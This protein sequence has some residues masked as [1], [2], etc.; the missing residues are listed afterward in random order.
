MLVTGL[1][2]S[3]K[4]TFARAL[5]ERDGLPHIE[6]DRMYYGP[7]FEMRPTF[8]SELS[9]VLDGP[10]WLVD[11]IGQPESR[12]LSWARADVLIWLDLP[13]GVAGVRALRRTW[14]RLR[15]REE[16]LPGCRESWL[17]WLTPKHPV[18]LALTQHR[19]DR[20]DRERRLA[21][22]RFAHLK[23]VRLRSR[24]EVAAFLAERS[25]DLAA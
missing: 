22:P 3:G 12:D 13:Y 11:D 6:V 23:V 20:R 14:G 16:M 9:E 1:P 21:D 2:A 5:A 25:L 24:A 10:A 15:A 7:S 19:R 18:R 17:G 4:T 8:V